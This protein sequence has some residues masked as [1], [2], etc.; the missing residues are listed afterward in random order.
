M[1]T[2]DLRAA[3]AMPRTTLCATCIF[4]HIVAGYE[5]PERIVFCGYAF[6]LREVPF[7]VKECS[8]FRTERP[9]TMEILTLDGTARR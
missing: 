2:L 6:P 1:I 7:P 4:S 9:V 5:P 3:R 8:D